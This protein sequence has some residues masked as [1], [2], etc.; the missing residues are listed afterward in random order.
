MYY[1]GIDGGGTKTAFALMNEAGDVVST[2]KTS[3]CY[4]P[5]LGK[6][7]LY[8]LLLSGIEACGKGVDFSEIVALAGIPLYGESE[9]LMLALEEMKERLPVKISFVNDVEVGFYGA[10]GF[11][12]GINIVAG[13]GSIGVGFDEG[14]NFARSG[15][16]GHDLGCD[17]GSAYYIGSRLINQFTRQVDLRA[18]R[19]L[20]YDVI[21]KELD[22]KDDLHVMSYFLEVVKMERYKIAQFSKL[23]NELALA[24]DEACIQIFRDAAYEIYLL[25]LGITRQLSFEERPIQVSYTGGV[26]K[27]GDLVLKPL[28]EFLERDGMELVEP[29]H[30]P[31]YGACLK[32]RRG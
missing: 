11:R 25:G 5:K 16:F 4:F 13:T 28:A 3:G 17:E 14:G 27:A 7:G 31:V 15:G 10:L 22:L 30:A 19:T 18:K 8:E 26:F 20:L 9:G 6:E 12:A 21:R 1:L 24:G 2:F 32:A 23:A 29:L